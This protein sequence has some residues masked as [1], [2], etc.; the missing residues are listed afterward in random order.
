MKKSIFLI[1]GIIL[2]SKF[3]LAQDDSIKYQLPQMTITATRVAEPWIEVPL[4]LNVINLNGSHAG[5]GYGFDEVLSGIPGVLAQSRYGNQDVRLTI[6]G[7]GARG[8]GE[9]SNAGTTRGIRVLIDGFPET[10]PDGRTS[11][12]LVDLSG[13]GKI[14]VVRSNASSIWGNASGGVVNVISNTDFAS[15]FANVQSYLGS[16]GFH[17]EMLKLGTTI[18]AGR[19][20]LSIS[21]T[22]TDGWRYHSDSKQTLVNAGIVSPLGER[23]SVGIYLTGS[24]NLF[25]IPGPLSQAQFDSL[26][27]QSDSVF[28]KRDERR[29]NRL[30]RLGVSLSHDINM[31]NS[32]SASAFINTKYLQRS[33]RN[34]FRDFNRYH[35]GGN[36]LYKNH[37]KLNDDIENLLLLGMDEAYQD[38]AVHFYN[39]TSSGNRSVTTKDNKRE[40]A[41]NFGTFIQN[42]IKFYNQLSLILGARY[43]NITYYYES[44][45]K[46]NLNDQKSFKNLTPKMGI[47]YKFSQTHSVYANIGGGVEVPAGNETDPSSAIADERID[48]VKGL[49]PLLEPI[50]STTFEV[51]TKQIF[52][53]GGDNKVATL[54][55]DVALYLINIRNDIIPYSDGGFFFTAGKTRRMGVEVA[56]TLQFDNGFS[57]EPSLTLSDNKYVE[58]QVDSAHYDNPGKVVDLKDNKMAGIPDFYYFLGIRYAPP[59]LPEVYAKVSIQGMGKYF[60]DDKNR[61]EVPS[62]NIINLSF[63]LEQMKIPGSIIYISG[64]FGV[65]NVTDKKYVSSVWINPQLKNGSPVF[66]E[67]G[68]PRN[69][70]GSLSVGMNL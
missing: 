2:L 11:M 17:K 44:Y 46:P 10:E 39:L 62:Y 20:F 66:I 49:N 56:S 18:D 57:I 30:G 41:N 55:Y 23:T 47:T 65:N 69:L 58:Y 36:I 3:C 24:S 26:A 31:D 70:I 19:L 67:P 7:F 21:N 6:R 16:Y 34:T 63:G 59:I 40:G 1:M 13:A 52:S 29:F 4:A 5:K 35:V 12:D 28:I 53:I 50:T 15:P 64:F 43:D 51:G 9:K 37:L 27:E 32:I 60:A 42:E 25:R 14:E 45:I 38:G 48:T 33:E 22:T 68:L 61:Y 8:A 54:I